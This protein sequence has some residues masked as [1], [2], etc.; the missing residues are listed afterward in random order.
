MG[1]H[2]FK[3]NIPWVLYISTSV[4]ALHTPNAGRNSHFRIYCYKMTLFQTV[5]QCF[6]KNVEIEPYKKIYL[7]MCGLFNFQEN[8]CLKDIKIFPTLRQW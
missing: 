2:L 5:Q 6:E 3:I 4:W 8:A 7:S 1:S